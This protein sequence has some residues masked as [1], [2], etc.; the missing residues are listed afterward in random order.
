MTFLYLR[1]DERSSDSYSG[2]DD[3]FLD[4]HAQVCF[5]AVF[6]FFSISVI[7][8]IA[9]IE[10]SLLFRRLTM[11]MNFLSGVLKVLS[12]FLSTQ[13]QVPRTI[14]GMV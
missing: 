10:T 8:F 5:F 7:N 2:R 12:F 1:F 11:R 13:N 4:M 6:F 9:L 3:F 14:I